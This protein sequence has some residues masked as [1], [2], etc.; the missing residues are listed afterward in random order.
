MRERQ[1][2]LWCL[3]RTFQ[4]S[5]LARD[6]MGWPSVVMRCLLSPLEVCMGGG[7]DHLL[8]G[9]SVLLMTDSFLVLIKL[10]LYGRNMGATS[11]KTINS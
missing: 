5:Q 4:Q 1:V 10:R 9:Q 6:G 7:K 8:P 3:A 2:Q 11:Q